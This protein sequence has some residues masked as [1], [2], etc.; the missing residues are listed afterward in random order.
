MSR[1]LC[2]CVTSSLDW[3]LCA[4]CNDGAANAARESPSTIVLIVLILIG[5]HVFL[6]SPGV[7]RRHRLAFCEIFVTCARI[8]CGRGSRALRSNHCARWNAVVVTQ[9]G[10]SSNQG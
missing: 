10:T 5:L 8:R 4:A 2:C 1:H 9:L 3:A 7:N 6:A